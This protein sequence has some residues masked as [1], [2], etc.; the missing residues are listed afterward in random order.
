ML[1]KSSAAHRN[2]CERVLNSTKDATRGKVEDLKMEQ[3]NLTG[4]SVIAN[5]VI[6][7][8]VIKA[9]SD[10]SDP[11]VAIQ[12]AVQA[13]TRVGGFSAN[14][15]GVEIKFGSD[16]T[17]TAFSITETKF[18]TD[19]CKSDVQKTNLTRECY[20]TEDGQQFQC[21]NFQTYKEVMCTMPKTHAF[22]KE[23]E[24]V[25]SDLFDKLC[26]GSL[27]VQASM[28]ILAL[29]FFISKNFY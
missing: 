18:E 17:V 2:T 8:K 25:P 7:L 6:A 20:V 29:G 21:S 12:N 24:P 22:Y 23:G 19:C 1:N 3:C 16:T 5:V 9:T 11:L 15:S 27:C 4:G 28:L 13:I 14:V 26:S 10:G